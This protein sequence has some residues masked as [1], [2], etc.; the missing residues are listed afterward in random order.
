MNTEYCMPTVMNIQLLINTIAMQ[1]SEGAATL[2]VNTAKDKRT[3]YKTGKIIKPRV[4]AS[5]CLNQ[6]KPLILFNT[7]PTIL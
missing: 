4:E 6:K 7:R 3:V 5:R 1:A 2:T